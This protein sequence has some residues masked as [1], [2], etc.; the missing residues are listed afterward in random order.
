MSKGMSFFY[1]ASKNYQQ[2][3]QYAVSENQIQKLFIVSFI[4][5]FVFLLIGKFS[6]TKNNRLLASIQSHKVKKEMKTVSLDPVVVNLKDKKRSHLTKVQVN[7]GTYE[8]SV[9]KEL[10]SNKNKSLEKHLLLVLSGQEKKDLSKNTN[11][12]EKK[13]IAQINEF[14]SSGKV[15]KINIQFIN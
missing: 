9:K 7:I 1:R 15:N 5:C 6:F 4:L 13:L 8:D 2:K 3:K 12:F 10:L 11:F 14:L